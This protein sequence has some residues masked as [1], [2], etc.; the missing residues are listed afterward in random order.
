[1]NLAR[2]MLFRTGLATMFAAHMP[3][4]SADSLT[5]VG[6]PPVREMLLWMDKTQH[7]REE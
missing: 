2:D 3:G 4:P 6:L 1:M 5:S 7:R